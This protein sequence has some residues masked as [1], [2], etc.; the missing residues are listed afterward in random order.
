MYYKE[1][2]LR[3]LASGM[4]SGLA[5]ETLR[6]QAKGARGQFDIFLSH[7]IV[8]A[9]LVL[10]VKRLLESQGL[11]VY[12]DWVDDP[13]LDRDA[14]TAATAERLRQRMRDARSLIYATSRAASPSKWM[15][16]ELGYFDG[17]K[18]FARISILPIENGSTLSFDG[19]EF[20]GL[21][22]VIERLPNAG[23]PRVLTTSGTSAETLRS[24]AAGLSNYQPVFSR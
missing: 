8:D 21:Y 14:V 7:S 11:T 16:W 15:P 19:Q 6:Q 23:G 13:A 20:L 10:G 24:F 1:Q 5:R 4:T 22:K 17:L 18:S 3:A 9:V 12:V 2:D